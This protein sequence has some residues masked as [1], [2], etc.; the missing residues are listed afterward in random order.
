MLL[1][2]RMKRLRWLLGLTGLSLLLA[3]GCAEP[4]TTRE[5]R[6]EREP[7]RGAGKS[8]PVGKNVF[9][10]VAGP[11]R[12]VVVAA[13]VVLRE[14]RLEGLLTRT[15]AKEHEY[16]LAADADGRTIHGTLL[17]LGGKPGSPV[18]FEPKFRPAHGSP[19]KVSLRYKKGGRTVTEPAQHWLREFDTRKHPSS[20]WVFAGSRL[21]EDPR[22]PN[23]PPMYLANYGD[24]I[25]VCNMEG[26]MLDLPL[27]SPTALE[28]RVYEAD[29][30]RIPPKGTPVEVLLEPK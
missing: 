27:K 2:H 17:T 8:G 19:I 22:N 1:D 30:E 28:T 10:E 13:V 14:G 24:L 9:L 23:A 16:I 25:C 18:Q 29:T 12:R 11:T 7:A 15:R 4:T 20:D 6:P 3:L 5:P 21:V 26:A